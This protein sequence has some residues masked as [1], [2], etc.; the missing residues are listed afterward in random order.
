MKKIFVVIGLKIGELGSA[1][2]IWYLLCL[3]WSKINF[4]NP[5][6]FWVGGFPALASIV[7]ILVLCSAFISFI[8]ANSQLADKLLNRKK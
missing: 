2:F 3:I 7:L 8:K 6:P 1:F 4:L 5:V